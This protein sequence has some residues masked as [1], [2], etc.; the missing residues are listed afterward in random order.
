[1]RDWQEIFG[2]SEFQIF[3]VHSN[4]YKLNVVYRDN[5]GKKHKVIIKDFRPY[6]YYIPYKKIYKPDEWDRIDY[7]YIYRL[8]KLERLT[9]SE[10]KD[11]P[12]YRKYEEF[13]YNYEADIPY[14]MRFSIDVHLLYKDNVY[15][16]IP[17][18]IFYIDIEV[19]N[20]N[21]LGLP[22][23]RNMDKR[24]Y[25]NVI[26][27]YDNYE[28]KVYSIVNIE[29]IKKKKKNNNIN[30]PNRIELIDGY[31]TEVIKVE[32]ER[33]LIIKFLKLINEKEP[34]LITGWNIL[35]FDIPYIVGR[36][37]I[38]NGNIK[39]NDV[40]NKDNLFRLW[41]AFPNIKTIRLNKNIKND[42]EKNRIK[43]GSSE[44][45]IYHPYGINVLDYQILY[46]RLTQPSKP[47]YTL[48]YI[49]KDELGE[50]YG[51]VKYEGSLDDLYINNSVLFIKYNAIDTLLVYFIERK[52]QYINIVNE[53]KN[54]SG[55]GTLEYFQDN[56]T[57]KMSLGVMIQFARRY[58]YAIRTRVDR[59]IIE[60]SG[61]YVRK[62]KSG[63]YKWIIDLDASSLYPSTIISLNISPDTFICKINEEDDLYRKDIINYITDRYD[64][65]IN[66]D[67][68]ENSDKYFVNITTQ[69]YDNK[70]HKLK[71]TK[72]II[73]SI[74]ELKEY[75]KMINNGDNK[76]IT[77][78]YNGCIYSQIKTGY[79]KDIETMFIKMRKEV[80]DRMIKLKI[81]KNLL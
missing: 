73:L 47:S 72:E 41:S 66:K 60:Y 1:M 19:Y 7:P 79:V 26:S 24:K 65:I 64:M 20:N 49:A 25:I 44:H 50:K 29:G 11:I 45:Y 48:D 27:I 70:E 75:I 22:K 32:N 77:V 59:E 10:P 62:P 74:K 52:K 3:Y 18:R 12:E 38:H 54:K 5:K 30:I 14:D 51:K 15:S 34:D 28:D 67:I 31:Y 46:K 53:L 76:N 36:I 63:I 57:N 68:I 78:S 8:N 81:L 9:V 21:E 35:D 13:M 17:P 80:K 40:N 56:Y 4:S 16:L 6:F 61:A 55:I 69:I 37:I 58:G 42:D 71:H 23:W 43:I 2:N 33:E 39:P